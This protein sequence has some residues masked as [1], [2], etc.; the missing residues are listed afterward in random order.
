LLL[1]YVLKL[2]FR[3]T[4]WLGPY[5]L[6]FYAAQWGMIGFG[7]MVDRGPGFITLLT[8]FL[9]LAATDYSYAKVGHGNKK[10]GT[11]IVLFFLVGCQTDAA[12]QSPVGKLPV[13][14]TATA[15]PI[16]SATET[17]LPTKTPTT[18]P[19]ETIT[20]VPSPTTTAT[21]TLAPGA[22]QISSIDQVV[23]VYIPAGEFLMGSTGADAGADYDEFPQHLVYLDAYWIGQTVVSNAMYARFLNEMGNQSAGPANWLDAGD[24]DVLI[25][26]NG[27]IWQPISGYE[28]HPA[29]E[30]TW[31]GALAY[32]QWSGGRLP[33]E[34]EWEKAARGAFPPLSQGEGMGVRVY[35][36]GDEI[37]CEKAQY[38]NCSGGLLPVD[39]HPAGAS[40]YGVLGL[41]GNT[42]EWVFD[43]YADNYYENSPAEN[44]P[45]PEEGQTRVLRGASWDYDWKHLRAANRRHNGPAVSMHDY[46]FRCVLDADGQD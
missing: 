21:P 27:G 25:F 37:D 12:A 20:S 33:T 35:P 1:D 45:G 39:A 14:T 26:Q 5:L 18:I 4:R 19:S 15:V 7:F 44:P 2:E 9:S 42:W 24:E 32:C 46:G 17:K 30:V 6:I 36:W 43:W 38:A 10:M 28:R 22:T 16:L 34:A 41:S 23:W 8:Y 3:Q 13:T 31:F 40:P 29:V 11:F